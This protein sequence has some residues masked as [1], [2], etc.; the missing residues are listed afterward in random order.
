MI[1]TARGGV[2]KILV[3]FSIRILLAIATL[4]PAII[5][6]LAVSLGASYAAAQIFPRSILSSE[7]VFLATISIL[8][9]ASLLVPILLMA[10]ICRQTAQQ[11]KLHLKNLS[12]NLPFINIL[13]VARE[14]SKFRND[15]NL[16][17]RDSGEEN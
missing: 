4:F 7:P 3:R 17:S 15:E 8:V 14:L 2:D 16:R 11:N 10:K 1:A 12:L 6:A 9:A 13:V 5:V